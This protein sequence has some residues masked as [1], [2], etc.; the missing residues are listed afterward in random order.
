MTRAGDSLTTDDARFRAALLCRCRRELPR[1]LANEISFSECAVRIR[2]GGDP[3]DLRPPLL[4]RT[5]MLHCIGHGDMRGRASDVTRKSAPMSLNSSG[6]RS[7]RT[8][9]SPS[10]GRARS[11]S[12]RMKAPKLPRGNAPASPPRYAWC[13]G[14]LRLRRRVE[15]SRRNP[16][17]PLS[18]PRASSA[19]ST[20]TSCTETPAACRD[21][22]SGAPFA[23]SAR[24]RGSRRGSASACPDRC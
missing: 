19:G 2:R 14:L 10:S 17:P 8:H 1:R 24:L 23:T 4:R 13:A 20:T 15:D 18:P 11:A 5:L 22:C 7:P 21:R 16:A 9:L 6:P 3:V 12:R